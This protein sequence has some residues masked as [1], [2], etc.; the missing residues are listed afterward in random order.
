MTTFESENI[1]ILGSEVIRARRRC[2]EATAALRIAEG[3]AQM[4]H[5]GLARGTLEL[6]H[7]QAEL[8]EAKEILRE[9]GYLVQ[10]AHGTL[11]RAERAFDEALLGA[12]ANRNAPCQQGRGD[13]SQKIHPIPCRERKD[14]KNIPDK[15]IRGARQKYI[16]ERIADSF[17]PNSSRMT[18]RKLREI[19][20]E[21]RETVSDRNAALRFFFDPGVSPPGVEILDSACE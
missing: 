17:K 20:R 7:T 3:V 15:L 14:V 13:L 4:A 2:V 8:R 1:A 6:E 18:T 19:R 11:A 21:A 9:A 16:D 10:T 12:L 5:E